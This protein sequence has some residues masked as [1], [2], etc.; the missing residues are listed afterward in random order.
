MHP[1]CIPKSPPRPAQWVEEVILKSMMTDGLHNLRHELHLN[2]RSALEGKLAVYRIRVSSRC[3]DVSRKPAPF[4]SQI[5]VS[6]HH[7]YARVLLATRWWEF[8]SHLLAPEEAS[9]RCKSMICPNTCMNTEPRLFNGKNSPLGG[10]LTIA[11]SG[12]FKRHLRMCFHHAA[13]RLCSHS[14]MTTSPIT[15]CLKSTRFVAH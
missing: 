6:L 10:T 2:S 11:L 12:L 4:R 1:S 15:H 14:C 8:N 9:C 3:F 13:H 5:P 7:C